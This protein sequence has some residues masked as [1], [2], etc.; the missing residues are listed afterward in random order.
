MSRA[1]GGLV[2]A[3]GVALSLLAGCPGDDGPA[4]TGATGGSGG[5][6]SG[7]SAGSAGAAGAPWDPEWHET[8]PKDW[9]SVGPDDNPDCG[10]GCRVALNVPITNPSVFGHGYTEKWLVSET[11]L[12]I[13]FA[14][15]GASVTFA[16]PHE[17]GSLIQ[18]SV[19]GDHVSYRRTYGTYGT[20]E[21]ASLLTGETKIAFENSPGT[22]AVAATALGPNH[23]FWETGG[24]WSRH[25]KTGVAKKL[26]LG[27]FSYCPTES[28]V[29]CDNGR[30]YT[31]DPDTGELKHLDYGAAWQTDGACSPGRTQYAWVDYRDPPGPGSGWL[32]RSGG[33]IYVHDLAKK[34]TTR[35]TFDSPGEPRG[36]VYPAI[37]GK[38]VVWSEPPDGVDANPDTLSSLQYSSTTLGSLD[39]STGQRCRLTTDAAGPLGFK[40]LHGRV[41][42]ASWLDKI[43]NEKRLVAL[44]LDHPAL[45]WSCWPTPG[46]TPP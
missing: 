7:G 25:L 27:C 22:G 2:V 40:S 18:H 24:L 41:L 29:L 23:V 37:A 33:E 21:I 32:Q 16:I 17:P 11:P 35:V 20:V 13:G 8:E 3:A 44:E 43:A 10:P 30:I 34:K 14:E 39:L 42:Y 38:W 46:W 19:W 15:V 12:G 6:G 28:L 1:L 31:I 9:P 4:G 45:E 36:K 26:T 5:L